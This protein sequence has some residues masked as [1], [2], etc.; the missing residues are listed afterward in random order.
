MSWQNIPGFSLDIESF[1]PE[2]A[3]KLP[4]RAVFVEVGVLFGRS[5]A[6]MG[7]LRPDLQLYGVDTWEN[8]DREGEMIAY[9]AKYGTTWQAFL[10]GMREHAPVVLDNLHIIRAR[11][12]D[13][14]VPMADA[15]F[16]DA[17]HTL[18]DVRADIQHWILHVKT[19]GILCG[20]DYVLPNHPGVVQAVNEW[21]PAGVKMGPKA[22]NGWT[23]C[24][25]VER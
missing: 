1:Y 7:T 20:H 11:S 23:S 21:F 18:E 22:G 8:G 4:E 17:G 9:Q 25:W 3:A 5:L 19:G 16:I 2:L 15:C 14:T 10:G 6:L 24:W 13:V 12:T